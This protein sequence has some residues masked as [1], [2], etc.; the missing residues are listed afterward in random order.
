MSFRILS[1]LHES[2]HRLHAGAGVA[3][4]AVALCLPV[5]LASCAD[6]TE[7]LYAR[8]RAFLRFTPVSAVAP[9]QTALR[10]PGMWCTVTVG[11]KAYAFRGNDGHTASYPFTASDAYGRPESVAGFILGTPSVPD[12][13]GQ[14]LP[15]AYDLVCPVCY[16]NDAVQR[17]LTFGT[18]A[19][20]MTCPRCGRIYSLSNNGIEISGKGGSR[21]YRYPL[22]Y[23]GDL[24]VVMN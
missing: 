21:L 9:L 14:L 16:E 12:L 10:N 6:T 20:T 3:A 8:Q 22:T 15:Q 13:N 24:V 5:L 18:A 11:T 1:L 23:S 4:W 7:G 19:E 17:S 2:L